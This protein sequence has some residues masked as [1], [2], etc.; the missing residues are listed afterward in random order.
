MA[1]NKERLLHGSDD[2]EDEDVHGHESR[3]TTSVATRY[4]IR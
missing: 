2:E 4:D 3:F 1:E